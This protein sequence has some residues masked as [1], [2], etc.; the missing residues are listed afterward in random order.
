MSKLKLAVELILWGSI[1][2]GLI[3]FRLPSLAAEVAKD[4]RKK[5]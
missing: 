3:V 1:V 2:M 5:K 4:F